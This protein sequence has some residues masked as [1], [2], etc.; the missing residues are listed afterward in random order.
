MKFPKHEQQ[1]DN[2]LV[3]EI[4]TLSLMEQKQAFMSYQVLKCCIEFFCDYYFNKHSWIIYVYY[5][6]ESNFLPRGTSSYKCNLWCGFEEN[7]EGRKEGV[8]TMKTYSL[9]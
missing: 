1:Y 5:T 7:K 3:L 9:F 6:K 2:L 4:G 8:A